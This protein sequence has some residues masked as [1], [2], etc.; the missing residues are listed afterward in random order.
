MARSDKAKNGTPRRSSPRTTAR[1]SVTAN[2]QTVGRPSKG[3]PENV[4]S[5]PSEAAVPISRLDATSDDVLIVDVTEDLL[6]QGITGYAIIGY[7]Q[8]RGSTD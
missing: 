4:A 7:R 6:R 3:A 8:R 1:R 2:A 5:K